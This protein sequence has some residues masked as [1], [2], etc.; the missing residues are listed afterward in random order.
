VANP[1]GLTETGVSVIRG[2]LPPLLA[3]MKQAMNA[4]I[5]DRRLRLKADS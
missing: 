2:S 5:R 1:G 4:K 3:E